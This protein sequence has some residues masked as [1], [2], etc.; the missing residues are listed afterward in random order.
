MRARVDPDV[1]TGCELCVT[2][3]PEVFEMEDDK[4]VAKTN[5]VP[6]EAEENC[7]KAAEECPVEAIIIEE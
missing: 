5:P 1:C 4:A 2:N 7:K 6:A 3:C